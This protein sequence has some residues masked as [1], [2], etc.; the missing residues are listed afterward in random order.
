MIDMLELRPL[1]FKQAKDFILKTH[2]H[3]QPS[4]GWKFGIGAYLENKLVGVVVVGR[5]VSRMLDDGLTAEVTRLSTDGTKN[6]CSKLY[7]A[8]S[9]AC[10][11]MGYK[12]L[13]TYI[14]DTENGSSLRA[15]GWKLTMERAG[16][17]SWSS[18]TRPR[19]DKAPTCTKQRWETGWST[20]DYE[21]YK[22]EHTETDRQM[23]FVF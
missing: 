15:S 20:N 22:T 6:A 8:A 2:R 21:T 1:T 4:V 11:S 3:H 17:G 5:P 7:A 14:L 13:I 12:R 19:T 10:R 9:Q 16:G 23:E 18:L